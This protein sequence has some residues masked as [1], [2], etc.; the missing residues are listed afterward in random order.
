MYRGLHKVVPAALNALFRPSVEG[1]EN[2]P[3][4][5][6][7]ILASNHLSGLDVVLM[8]AVLQRPLFFVG[9]SEYFRGPARWFFR[10]V[11]VIPVARHGGDAAEASL[12]K[13]QEILECGQLLGI[14]P[15]GTRSPDGRLHRGK[16]G[17]VRLAL[18]TGAPIVPVAMLGTN[19]AVVRKTPVPR[20]GRVGVRFG[21]PIDVQRYAHRGDEKFAL[22]SATDE[23]MYE[24]MLLSGQEY[25]DEYA[26]AVKAGGVPPDVELDA[27]G[28][29]PDDVFAL[30]EAS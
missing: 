9:K 30:P 8:P 24:L 11:G 27:F 13:G 6:P 14:Y 29:L 20:L 26:A 17:P 4:R 12:R 28:Q 1:I 22:R 2:V 7:A 19:R 5:G 3:D 18:R 23:V 10:N 16:T 21:E 15:E 25:V